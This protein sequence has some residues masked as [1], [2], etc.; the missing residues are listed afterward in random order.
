M[1]MEPVEEEEV[2]K[3]ADMGE[4]LLTR[5]S[6]PKQALALPATLPVAARFWLGVPSNQVAGRGLA[7]T[8]R[9][10]GKAPTIQAE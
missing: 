7:I 10:R 8:S 1:P 4:A 2:G 6:A 9:A 3:D 5:E